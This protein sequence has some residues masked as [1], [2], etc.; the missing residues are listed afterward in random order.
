MKSMQIRLGGICHED[1]ATCVV[2][3]WS[4]PPSV[5]GELDNSWSNHGWRRADD[6]GAAGDSQRERLRPARFPRSSCLCLVQGISEKDDGV[7]AKTQCSDINFFEA[8]SWRECR[9]GGGSF[10]RG[11]PAWR[12]PQHRLGGSVSDGN[13]CS[14]FPAV[15]R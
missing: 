14:K 13:I 7:I 3:R 4:C 2:A 8:K 9:S 6:A 5:T 1:L 11:T 15:C 10:A 12:G